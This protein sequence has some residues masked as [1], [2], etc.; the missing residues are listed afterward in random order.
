MKPKGERPTVRAVHPRE[1]LAM[2]TSYLRA[3]PEAMFWMFGPAT[4]D[5][6]RLGESGDVA[7]VHVRGPLEQFDDGWGD[8]YEA[9][10]RRVTEAMDGGEEGPPACVVLDLSTPGGVVAGLNETVYALRKLSKARGIPLHAYVNEYAASAGYAL[11]CACSSIV[12]PPS[13]IMGSVGVIST[14]ASQAAYDKKQGFQYALI[15][16]GARK[17]DG[18]PHAPITDAAI[19]AETVRVNKLAKAFFRLVREARGIDAKPLEAAIYL[20]KDALKAGL[21]DE[22]LP[23][24]ELLFSLSGN[25]APNLPGGNVTK[26]RANAALDSATVSDPRSTHLTQELLESDMSTHALT[27]AIKRTEA[28]LTTEKDPEKLAALASDLAAY[29]K[30]K[31]TIEKHE[32]E[33]GDEEDEE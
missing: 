22:V 25:A 29:K 4:P 3:G 12:A 15:T 27:A 18:H 11:A 19:A 32:S 10:R 9:I 8:S 2:D 30:S 1:A 24:E 23:W 17:A 20:A 28:A 26:R 5:T 33:E 31:H 13:A 7:A 14:Q 16:S 6:E 21:C